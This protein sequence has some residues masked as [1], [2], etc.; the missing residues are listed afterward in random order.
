[1]RQEEG[2]PAI[3][4]FFFNLSVPQKNFSPIQL[5]PLA[6]LFEP[7]FLCPCSIIVLLFAFS[8]FKLFPALLKSMLKGQ[9]SSG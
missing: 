6:M 4:G 3:S 7:S 1:M 8:F 5:T 9:P 2:M